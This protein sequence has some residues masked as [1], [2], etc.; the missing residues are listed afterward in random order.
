[1]FTKN[2]EKTLSTVYMGDL[3]AR[4]ESS[5]EILAP[6]EKVFTFVADPKNH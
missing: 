5:V 3:M 2:T 4:V 1:M 6:I